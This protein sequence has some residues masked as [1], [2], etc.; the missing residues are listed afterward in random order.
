MSKTLKKALIFIAA[1]VVVLAVIFLIEILLPKNETSV[2]S[3][4]PPPVSASV[5]P[6]VSAAA[7]SSPSETPSPSP[8]DNG[9]Y[10]RE[11]TPDGA[12]YHFT[13]PGGSVTYAVTVDDGSF[14]LTN[15]DGHFKFTSKTDKNEFLDV[16]F[17][18]GAKGADLAPSILNSYMK[19]KEFEQSGANYIDG[20]K[21]TGETVAANDGT[22]EMTAWLVDTDKGVLAVVISCTM[23]DRAAE[24]AQLD[25]ILAT[26][27]VGKP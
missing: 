26:L 23:A 10:T 27:T 13:V 12:L 17:I 4:S 6:T 24:T 16:S 20:T 22:T 15:L 25:K 7:S 19:Y 21:I 18:E 5:S 3:P 14:G 2:T 11:E 1:L 9:S 8:S